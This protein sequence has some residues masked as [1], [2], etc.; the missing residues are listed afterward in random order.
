M[1]MYRIGVI[2]DRDSI[3]GFR[4]LGLDVFP[5]NEPSETAETLRRLGREGYGVVYITEQAAAPVMD[6]ID[7]FSEKMHPA[8]I[9]IPGIRGNPGIGML[10]VR[11]SVEKAVGADIIFRDEK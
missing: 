2:G 6:V 10:N 4:A 9:L 11:K 8:V 5:V 7:E 3:L 1:L